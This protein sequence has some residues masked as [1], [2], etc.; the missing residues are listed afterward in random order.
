[1]G[2]P[3]PAVLV[4]GRPV[5]HENDIVRRDG[6]LWVG[7]ALVDRIAQQLGPVR[8]SQPKPA[9][10]KVPP[11]MSP[12]RSSLRGTVVVLDAGHGGKDPGAANEWGP[13]EKIVAMDTVRQVADA[14]RAYGVRLILTR[15]DDTFVELDDRV[16]IANDARADLFV[17]IHADALPSKTDID[18][19]TL[20]IAPG[21][22]PRTARLADSIAATLAPHVNM[23]RGI[24][25]N[26]DFRVLVN[27][28]MPAVLVELGY[29]TNPAEAARLSTPAYRRRLAGAIAEGI[30]A[31]LR[32]GKI[33]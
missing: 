12:D 31:Y 18:G 4:D 9:Q 19:F 13:P 11:R 26:R 21:A 32:A 3:Q 27:T 16:A 22:S 14:L 28:R 7:P 15:S 29:L 20:Y 5:D 23:F 10:A 24:R 25:N 8:P 33:D 30:A 6:Q 2:P 1:M 17:S